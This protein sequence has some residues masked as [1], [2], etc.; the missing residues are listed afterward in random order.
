MAQNRA[1]E[2]H[3]ISDD[4]VF[5]IVS[6]LHWGDVERYCRRYAASPDEADDMV[7]ATFIAAWRCARQYRGDGPVRHW[8]LRIAHS[9]VAR[10]RR[11]RLQRASADETVLASIPCERDE[12]DV[13][14]RR[15]E[16][17][18]VLRLIADLPDR[19]RSIV[20]WRYVGG[21]SVDEV[22]AGMRC[23]PGTVKAACH[24]ALRVIRA[25]MLERG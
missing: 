20:L 18:R 22:A 4:E 11:A 19:Q 2:R 14:W 6:Q 8:L 12:T 24:S 15:D 16:C 13:L 1:D 10:S 25:R 7:Q 17:E 23:A 21:Y 5:E 3:G 9:V